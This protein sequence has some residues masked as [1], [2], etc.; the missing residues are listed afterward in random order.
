[1]KI[2]ITNDDGI[3]SPG[4]AVLTEVCTSL[5]HQ[6]IVIA[7][8]I[9]H[10]Y[11]SHRVTARTPI[12]VSEIAPD[13]FGVNGT[14]AD[15]A[16]LAI[17]CLATDAEWLL[18]G[19]NSGGNLGSDIYSSGTIAAA[20]EAALFGYKSIAISQF[21]A[22]NQK[23]NKEVTSKLSAKILSQLLQRDLKPGFFWNVNLPHLK[24]GVSNCEIVFCPLDPS[25]LHVQYEKNENT[26][27]FSGD[28][29]SRER[30]SG[31]DL[32]EC[33]SGKIT[34]TAIPLQL[35]FQFD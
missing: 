13:R 30:L 21:H 8:L 31:H 33:F 16:R 34:V 6:P 19:I 9:E 18:S 3:D 11:G 23:V 20:R 22:K 24:D 35:P 10:S 2:V 17:K 29:H 1:M 27:L 5:G 26:Y 12:K 15:C 25:P 28:Y 32:I 7:P 4:I 14:P